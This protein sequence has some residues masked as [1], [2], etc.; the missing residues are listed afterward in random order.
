MKEVQTVLE[1]LQRLD[2]KEQ[3]A[4]ELEAGIRELTQLKKQHPSAS[5]EFNG[6]RESQF[7]VLEGTFTTESLQEIIE[8]MTLVPLDIRSR[9]NK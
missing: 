7:V 8:V 3:Q 6:N 1:M 4:A 9:W 2:E 5:V